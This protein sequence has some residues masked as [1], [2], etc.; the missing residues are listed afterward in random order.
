M[1]FTSNV[2]LFE[3]AR[4][5]WSILTLR[6]WRRRKYLL[7]I[8]L[9]FA[10]LLL[11]A[12]CSPSPPLLPIATL[13]LTHTAMPIPQPTPIPTATPTLTPIPS[14]QSILQE[15]FSRVKAAGSY[16][17]EMELQA[18][19]IIGGLME[20]DF[21]MTYTVVGDFQAPDRVRATMVGELLGMTIEAEY[22]MIRDTMHVLNPETGEWEIIDQA[23][24]P[25]SFEDFLG[26]EPAEIEELQLVGEEMLDETR[27]YH[28]KGKTPA[29]ATTTL[30]IEA[31]MGMDALG[32]GGE[33]EYESEGGEIEYWMGVDDFYPRQI[34]MRGGVRTSDESPISLIEDVEM[35]AKLSEFGQELP[36]PDPAIRQPTPTPVRAQ[37]I[38][39][40]VT[41]SEVLADALVAT[42]EEDS[43]HLVIDAQ[44]DVRMG[45]L[46]TRM[47]IIAF[48]GD[49]Q[50]PDR[51]AGRMSAGG[52]LSSLLGNSAEKDIIAIGDTAYTMDPATGV[53]E[54][55][56]TYRG[57]PFSPEDILLTD[58]SGIEDLIL[59][60]ET[61]LEGI[62][63]YHLRGSLPGIAPAGSEAL[64]QVDFWIEVDNPRLRQAA[65]AIEQ[66]NPG[67][68]LP[69][70]GGGTQEIKS[71]MVIVMKF[72]DF[73]KP[74][75]IELPT[76]QLAAQA[77]L[78][79]GR[80][81]ALALDISGA[82][83][84]FEEALAL[85]ETLDLN[86]ETE[87]KRIAFESL[88]INLRL[89]LDAGEDEA[90]RGAIQAALE[91]SQP[92]LTQAADIWNRL[93]WF[94]SIYDFAEQVV[95]SACQWGVELAGADRLAGNR[96]SRGLA[97]ALSGDVAGAIEDFAYFV[98][99]LNENN[100]G[101]Q[102][103][104]TRE[105]WI[106]RLEAGEDPREI[107]D[108]ETLEAL[109]HE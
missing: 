26:I 69:F 57:L 96:D 58:P 33:I 18:E 49:F 8:S 109:K 47:P 42:S 59:I 79:E 107:F 55:D 31:P 98:E 46:R 85:D 5:V 51:M 87:A 2:V 72:S 78:D 4:A 63:I 60:E 10:V 21:S 66:A 32:I 16:H 68:G 92:G 48:E 14:P 65:L 37:P 86:P 12:A 91:L 45:G 53:W 89:Q 106:R 70:A 19:A 40:G 76:K 35:I 102:H 3:L 61:E 84:K 17:L 77:L 15:G 34:S 1:S 6:R 54:K 23:L 71:S 81:L 41:L 44:V 22:I 88:L 27:V 94:G 7:I 30:G 73:G 25:F 36:F 103:L 95:D 100:P 43:Y 52:F 67:G 82:I 56:L 29:G 104:E 74:V 105:T 80:T 83:A 97:R 75:T 39:V 50:S 13:T 11:G 108:A 64:S 28:L 24:V 62:H 93:C 99:W 9:S 20:R 101:A 90:V 38:P